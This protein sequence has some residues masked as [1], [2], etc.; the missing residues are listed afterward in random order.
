[1]FTNAFLALSRGAPLPSPGSNRKKPPRTPAT[2]SIPFRAIFPGRRLPESSACCQQPFPGHSYSNP[3]MDM[4]ASRIG[5]RLGRQAIIRR[6]G[7]SSGPGARFVGSCKR[8]HGSYLQIAVYHAATPFSTR[9]GNAGKAEDLTRL[10]A[11]GRCRPDAVGLSS[12]FLIAGFRN[13]L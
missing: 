7:I 12:P 6:T 9:S 10:P 8:R 11:I 4:D 5:S 1:M 13:M 3:I 2:K